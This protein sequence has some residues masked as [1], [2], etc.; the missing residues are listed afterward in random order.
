VNPSFIKGLFLGEL[1]EELGFPFP[2]LS[3]E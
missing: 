3:D 2:T 1:R